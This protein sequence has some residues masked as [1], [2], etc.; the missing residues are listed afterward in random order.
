MS[1]TVLVAILS[2]GGTLLGTFGGIMTSSKLT[3]YRIKQLEIKVEKHNNLVERV[4]RL[5]D[6]DKLIDEKIDNANHRI[7]NL[8][9]KVMKG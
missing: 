7:E 3:E 2:L 1:D 6:N 4:F 8:E 9:S 5:E